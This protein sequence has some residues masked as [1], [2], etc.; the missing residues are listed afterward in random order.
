MAEHV[1]EQDGMW[2][3]VC[4]MWTVSPY[5]GCSF[6]CV[7]CNAEAQ[8]ESRP[9][10]RFTAEVERKLRAL[11]ADDLVGIGIP[12]DAYPPIED[13]LGLTRWLIASLTEAGVRFRIVTKGTAIL[14]DADLL[15]GNPL[16]EVVISLGVQEA[17]GIRRLE[18]GTASYQERRDTAFALAAAGVQVDIAGAPWIP[19]LTN[20]ADIVATFAPRLRV[21]FSA[22]DLGNY[23]EE[24]RRRRGLSAM[25]S[26]KRVFGKHWTQDAINYA[27]LRE[28]S[29]LPHSPHVVWLHPPGT[30]TA[31]APVGMTPQTIQTLLAELETGGASREFSMATARGI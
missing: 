31:E 23:N 20:S 10:P 15:A 16:A 14:R 12:A 5:Q 6:R 11:G 1:S 24:G 13:T 29:A 21:F 30:S 22:L 25:S 17:A 28:A 26:A 19:G 27:F 18:P 8:G 2:L 9:D 7:Y 4:G 3:R